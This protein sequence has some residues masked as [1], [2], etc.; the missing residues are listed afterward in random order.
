MICTGCQWHLI[1]SDDTCWNQGV[2]DAI[3]SRKIP[4]L[5][6]IFKHFCFFSL[7]L[8]KKLGGLSWGRWEE[9]LLEKVA[10]QPAQQPSGLILKMFYNLNNWFAPWI[11]KY[12]A[13]IDCPYI[14]ISI[15]M[16]V[17]GRVTFVARLTR[18]NR[19]HMPEGARQDKGY[20]DVERDE[21]L[22]WRYCWK[23]S[24]LSKY[25]QNDKYVSRLRWPPSSR[26]RSYPA[27]KSW[28][29]GLLRRGN[30]NAVWLSW[31]WGAVFLSTGHRLTCNCLAGTI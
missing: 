29:R 21:E 17:R 10:I 31:L 18:V 28:A 16:A 20:E 11:T 24:T 19:G 27:G 15:I 3:A 4:C 26:V 25:F 9:M 12:I 8:Y 13:F 1:I 23:C 7:A 6:S 2:N 30:E 22:Q 14:L 5:V